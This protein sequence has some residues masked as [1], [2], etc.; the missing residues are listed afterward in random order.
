MI[1]ERLESID[2]AADGGAAVGE[3]DGDDESEGGRADCL[4]SVFIVTVH[5]PHRSR[6]LPK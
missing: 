6:A 4:L 1:R 3:G 5:L 2:E